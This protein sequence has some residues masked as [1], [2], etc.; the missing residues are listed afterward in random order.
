MGEIICKGLGA[1]LP[2]ESVSV[3]KPERRPDCRKI[4]PGDLVYIPAD[5]SCHFTVHPVK[6]GES[7]WRIARRFRV[8][9]EW[10]CA[11]PEN[12]HLRSAGAP[13]NFREVLRTK[14]QP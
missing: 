11:L 2:T 3:S 10:L 8:S 1:C 12:Q 6:S 7:L 4:Y 5:P 14:A 13:D 9:A